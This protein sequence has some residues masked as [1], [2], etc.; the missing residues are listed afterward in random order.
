MNIDRNVF[1]FVFLNAA[2]A[3]GIA[4][5]GS[6]KMDSPF[7]SHGLPHGGLEM[8]GETWLVMTWSCVIISWRQRIG[9]AVEDAVARKGRSRSFP[10]H[11]RRSGLT[12]KSGGSGLDPCWLLASGIP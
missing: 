8:G 9:A 7:N 2:Q 6:L 12:D 5:Q 4:I 11:A 10:F 3:P 1:P